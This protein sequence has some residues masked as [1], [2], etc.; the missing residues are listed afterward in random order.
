MYVKT[1]VKKERALQFYNLESSLYPKK[2]KKKK[3]YTVRNILSCSFHFHS[4]T[5]KNQNHLAAKRGQFFMVYTFFLD[6]L[7]QK[8]REKTWVANAYYYALTKHK[9]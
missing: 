5:L 4:L 1:D 3:S 2:K 9:K 7:N 8:G 6:L